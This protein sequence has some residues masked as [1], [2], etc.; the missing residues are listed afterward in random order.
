MRLLLLG[1][2]GAGKGTQAAR[3][4]KT[5]SIPQLSTGDMLRT[6][7][8]AGT[9]LG[10]QVKAVMDAGQLVSD[11]LVIGIVADRIGQP[12]CQ[13]GF[14]LDG[15]P[16]TFGQAEALDSMLLN[17]NMKLDY[18]IELKVKEEA[19]LA[20]MEKRVQETQIN[21]QSIRTDDNPDSFRIRLAAYR[22][23]T[24]AVAD[25]YKKTGLLRSVDGMQS[26]EQVSQAIDDILGL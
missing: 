25:Y 2:P 18:V 13:K 24:A 17:H 6:A 3:L 14:I 19:L 7:V 9:P 10:L 11:K 21:G 15:F 22:A 23:Q 8:Q 12:D 1:P 26:V 5:L 16:R 4:V 20:R